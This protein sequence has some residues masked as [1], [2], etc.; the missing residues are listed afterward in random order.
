MINFLNT[1]KKELL[2]FLVICCGAFLA[3]EIA[4]DISREGDLGG[5]IEA[6]KLAWSREYI[7]SAHRN[8]WPP[9]MSIFAIPLHWLNELSFYGLRL[10][11]LL[12]TLVCY[13]YIF[14]W[15]LA[16]FLKR[17]LVFRFS[18]NTNTD[19]ALIDKLFLIPFLLTF[20]IF[21]E[22][23]SNL[24]VNILLLLVCI[25]VLIFTMRNKPILAGFLLAIAIS[26]KVYPIIL[27]PF[28]IYKQEYKTTFWTV[29]GLAAT[30]F[31]T[32]LYFGQGS[33]SLYA[34]WYTKQVS[35]GLQCIHF[36]Q[37]LWSFVCGLFSDT[38]RFENFQYNV[39]ALS[40]TQTKFVSVGIILTIAL[41]VAIRFF[42][43]TKGRESLATQWFIVLSFIPTFSPLSWKCY[44]VFLTPVIILLYNK[45]N[46]TS[47]AWLLYIPLLLITF[48]SELFIGNRLSDVTEALGVITFSS[49]FIS[50]L[51]TYKLTNS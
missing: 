51:A 12:G 22:E 47:R 8:T 14:K 25:L 41:F 37:S 33:T 40:T 6:G 23:V 3:I 44:F 49:L 4:R 48:S 30:Y 27:L 42:R 43:T 38:A 34:E 28:L 13:W 18:S 31:I 29:F 21:I 15:T 45:M 26:T 36:N 50:L 20:R 7:Y 17:N 9:F 39:A 11:W 16:S 19:V 5:Y 10:I 35:E 1:Y 2:H 24:Q 32:L 46:G